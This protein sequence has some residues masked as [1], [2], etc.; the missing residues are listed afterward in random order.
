MCAFLNPHIQAHLSTQEMS[1]KNHNTILFATKSVMAC[2]HTVFSSVSMIKIPL[3]N[4]VLDCTLYKALPF[5]DVKQ[6][7][8]PTSTFFLRIKVFAM[9]KYIQ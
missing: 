6:Y 7:I 9:L 3:K 5:L 8:R 1:Y 4:T 2:L